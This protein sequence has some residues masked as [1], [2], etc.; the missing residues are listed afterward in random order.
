MNQNKTLQ[1]EVVEGHF[2]SLAKIPDGTGDFLPELHR[3][4]LTLDMTTHFGE[5][6][7]TKTSNTADARQKRGSKGS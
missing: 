2:A 3:A 7:S 1:T 6:M 5:E 4:R